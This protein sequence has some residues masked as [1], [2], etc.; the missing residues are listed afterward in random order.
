MKHAQNDFV[1]CTTFPQ[2]TQ[3]RLVHV[4][5]RLEQSSFSFKRADDTVF[6]VLYHLRAK[7]VDGN[8]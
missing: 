1:P 6:F 4:K 5:A 8:L 3:N 7:N 2:H